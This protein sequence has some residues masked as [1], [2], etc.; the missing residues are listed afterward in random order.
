MLGDRSAAEDVIQEVFLRLHR[1]ASGLDTEKDPMPWLRSIT[2]NLCRDHWRSFANKVSTKSDDVNDSASPAATL[3]GNEPNPEEQAL[4][5]EKESL[6]QKAIN[7]LPDQLREIVVLRNFEGLEHGT[8][9]EM[10]G[11][12]PAAVR[13]RYSRALTQLGDLLKDVWP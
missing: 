5:L 1:A 9:A 8:I 3:A 4:I 7:N 10:V 2:A 11:I 6:V 13:K 12:S